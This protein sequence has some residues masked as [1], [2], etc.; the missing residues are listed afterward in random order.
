MARLIDTTV[1]VDLERRRLPLSVLRGLAFGEP[2]A[3]SAISAT[4]LL[5]GVE[6]ANTLERRRE[7]IAFIESLL[8]DIP[9]LPFDL[10]VARVHARVWA[11]LLAT[12]KSIAQHD[13]LIAATA[14]AHSFVMVTD[15]VRDFERVPGLVVHRPDW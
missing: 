6:R 1:L 8:T 13:L 15:N 14:M 9:V 7:R 12:G 3:M 10:P 5:V 2:I 4:E 11:Q